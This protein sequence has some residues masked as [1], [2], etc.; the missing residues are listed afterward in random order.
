MT[1]TIEK[2]TSQ[3]STSRVMDIWRKILDHNEFST[4]DSFFDVGGHSL[5]AT[6]LA[7]ALEKEF[8]IPLAAEIIFDRPTVNNL[9]EYINQQ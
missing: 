7:T 8:S 3:T 6:E 1:M 5:V 9:V 2:S 4:D